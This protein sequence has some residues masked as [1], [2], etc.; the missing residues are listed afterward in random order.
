MVKDWMVHEIAGIL[1][2]HFA[3]SLFEKIESKF[4]ET[5]AGI[6]KYWEHIIFRG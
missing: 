1:E 3:L 5:P 4:V 6:K 2:K